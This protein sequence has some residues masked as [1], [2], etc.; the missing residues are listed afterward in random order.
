[1]VSESGDA[2]EGVTVQAVFDGEV[3]A[4]DTTD[5]DG[6]FDM[7][8]AGLDDGATFTVSPEDRSAS[9]S[10]TYSTGAST[11][12]GEFQ[13]EAPTTTPPDDDDDA[14]G[15]GGGGGGGADDGGETTTPGDEPAAVEVDVTGTNPSVTVDGQGLAFVEFAAA[16][17]I[18]DTVSVTEILE[19][20]VAGP[21]GMAFVSGAEITFSGSGGDAV[22]QIRKGVKQSRLDELDVTADQLVI[23]HLNEE[24]DEW[25]AL[26][27]EVAS[28]DDTEVVLAAP[29]AGF[30]TYA[31][32]AQEDVTTTT[33][34]PTPTTTE[35][36]TTTD[37]PP[38]T[39]EVTTTEGPDED[40]PG[41]TLWIILGG[42]ILV[43]LL[44][45]WWMR[46]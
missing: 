26:D 35:A 20:P 16:T 32:F 37:A 40:G 5:A 15:G 29:S 22:E 4:N 25:E 18:D 12:V 45:Y 10:L 30:S 33:T 6:Y 34:E 7:N 3:V 11:D 21:G 41:T 39:T 23:H 1:M 17:E 19:P 31:V 2:I 42:G 36:P 9:E 8:V 13:I 27:T 24:T 46:Q 38:T 44:A 28:E 43:V 14:A